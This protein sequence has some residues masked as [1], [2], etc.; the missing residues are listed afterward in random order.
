MILNFTNLFF[1][2]GKPRYI[3]DYANF[4]TN[5]TITKNLENT[6]KVPVFAHHGLL[7]ASTHLT[8]S[9]NVFVSDNTNHVITARS[10]LVSFLFHGV[11]W[12]NTV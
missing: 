4:T 5:E 12:Y 1:V 2:R 3:N 8:T 7:Y 9:E 6:S 11:F 10:A